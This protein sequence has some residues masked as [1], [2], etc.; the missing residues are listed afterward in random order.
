MIK[1]AFSE[2]FTLILRPDDCRLVVTWDEPGFNDPWRYFVRVD[3]RGI[4]WL[5]PGHDPLPRPGRRVEKRI[6]EEYEKFN[7]ELPF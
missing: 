4:H 2:T 6:L 3:G 5:S 1:K 7:D